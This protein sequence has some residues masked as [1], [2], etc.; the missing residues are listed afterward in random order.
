MTNSEGFHCVGLDLAWGM[1]ARTGV[2]VVASDGHLVAS[3]SVVHDPEIRDFLRPYADSI[4]TAAIDAPLVVKNPSGQRPCERQIGAAFGR[5]EASAHSSNLGRQYFVAPRGAR[6]AEHFGWD[7]DPGVR[8]SPGRPTCIE[9]YP[10]PAMVSLFGLDRTIKYKGRH[11]RTVIYRQAAFDVLLGHM[12]THLTT[13]RLADHPRWSALRD[14]AVHATRPVDLETIEDEIDAIFCAHL[15]WLW[16]TAPEGLMVFG[17]FDAGYIVTPPAPGFSLGRSASSD[18]GI[19]ATG[20][21]R[22]DPA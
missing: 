4:R 22:D 9:V 11:G 21:A 8:P 2:A 6:L 18:A 15:A 5:F 3:A 16:V 20:D 7:M 13:L 10:H 1:T 12:A 14:I 17:D 19:V